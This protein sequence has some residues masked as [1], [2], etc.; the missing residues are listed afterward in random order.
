MTA[1]HIGMGPAPTRVATSRLFET[2]LTDHT[3]VDHVMIAGIC[4][5]LDPDLEVGTLINP[6][7]IIDHVSG[8]TFRHDPPGD[9]PKAGKLIT[10]EEATLDHELS[11]ALLRGRLPRGG[12]GVLGRRRGLRGERVSVVGLPV[13]RRPV[14]RWPARPAVT[15][16]HQPG[17]FGHA[18][19]INRL[20]TAEPELAVNLE[21][22]S[23]DT[24]LAARLAAEAAV[25]GCLAAGR[26]NPGHPGVVDGS[27]RGGRPHEDGGG[28]FAAS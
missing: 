16:R 2:W 6:E 17:R 5:G 25:R 11:R 4:G 1:I 13:H 8:A 26:L 24:T 9:A 3:P 7:I 21:R 12:H 20:L 15:W 28:T 14:L 18:A 27:D 10:T 19:E 22:L 23:H